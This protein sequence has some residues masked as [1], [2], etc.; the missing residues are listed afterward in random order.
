MRDILFLL[1]SKTTMNPINII[2]VDDHAIVRAG[3]Q[4]LLAT[5]QSITVL[6][7]AERGEQACQ[8]YAD[9]QPDVV[10]LD[11]SMAGIGGLE[12]TRRLCQ[13]DSNANI[14]IFSVHDENVYIDR[15]LNA[16]AKGYISKNA[17]PDILIDAI[18]CVARGELYIEQGL[19]AQTLNHKQHEY[20]NII[21]TLSPREFD[22]FLL[23]AKGYTAHKIADEL[24]LGYKTVANYSTQIKNKLNISSLAELVHI[25][26]LLDLIKR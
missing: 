7:E 20:K 24:C 11:L 14:L 19:L 9:L 1:F 26:I 15:A 18:H 10:V 22:V 4:M 6:A 17:H 23:L 8:L 5:E 2:L 13:R 3:F 25:A 16:G 21:E 12:T